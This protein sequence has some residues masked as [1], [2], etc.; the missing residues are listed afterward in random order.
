MMGLCGFGPDSRGEALDPHIDCVRYLSCLYQTLSQD[1]HS[2]F[3]AVSLVSVC[4]YPSRATEPFILNGYLFLA[5][6][7]YKL[8]RRRLI[9]IS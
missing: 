1:F 7:G 2:S 6:I 8:I 3:P 4:S 5:R 9:W